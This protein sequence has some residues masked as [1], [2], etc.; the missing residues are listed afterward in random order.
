MSGQIQYRAFLDKFPID[1]QDPDVQQLY[2]LIEHQPK[3]GGI[4][5]ISR[6]KH[7]EYVTKISD[8]IARL[9]E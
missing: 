5:G 4:F 7:E 6:T 1:S 9:E 3:V 8:T 2:C